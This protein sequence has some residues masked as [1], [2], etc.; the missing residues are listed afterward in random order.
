MYSRAEQDM[1]P[2]TAIVLAYN[3]AE[4]IER[5]LTEFCEK[6]ISKIPGSEF[7]VAED[8][9]VDGTSEIIQKLSEKYGIYHL[10]SKE[11]KG[12]S[13]A[14]ISAVL[15]AKNDYIFFFDSGLKHN[16]EDFW[17]LYRHRKNYD[18]IVGR[19]TGRKDQLYRRFFTFAYNWYLR[20]YFGLES[21]YD[22]DS[23]FKLFNR[24]V[25]N[26]VFKKGLIFTGFVSSEIVVRSIFNQLKYLEVP[27]SYSQRNGSSRGLPLKQI[28]KEILIVLQKARALRKE[29]M[30]TKKQDNTSR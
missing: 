8:G 3:E 24:C 10:T 6:V 2:V 18:L 21:V 26:T 9:S 25:I 23:G 1:D 14:L 15:A 27:I 12:Y 16:P 30:V 22:A 11:R 19:K 7:I 29:L 28:P 5:E 4:T 13:K 17:E 20:Q